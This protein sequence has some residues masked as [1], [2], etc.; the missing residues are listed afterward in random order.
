MKIQLITLCLYYTLILLEINLS[1]L[2]KVIKNYSHSLLIFMFIYEFSS[3]CTRFSVY[4]FCQH[5]FF[6]S[7]LHKYTD[8]TCLIYI[9]QVALTPVIQSLTVFLHRQWF[10]Y[11]KFNS[12]TLI[13]NYTSPHWTQRLFLYYFLMCEQCKFKK[14]YRL[15]E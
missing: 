12:L 10:T 2:Y 4:P 5:L 9:G 15:W 11:V 13:T 6:L 1:C 14:K 8:L 7:L 3:H